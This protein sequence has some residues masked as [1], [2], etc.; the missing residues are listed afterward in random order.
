MLMFVGLGAGHAQAAPG[1]GSYDDLG[2]W[3]DIYDSRLMESAVATVENL[4]ERGS[5]DWDGLAPLD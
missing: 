4:E 5:A 1:L 2:A 3:V